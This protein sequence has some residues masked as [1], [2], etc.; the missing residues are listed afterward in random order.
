M[1]EE[2]DTGL[3]RMYVPDVMAYIESETTRDPTTAVP[4]DS[5][6]LLGMLRKLPEDMEKKR[7]AR[8]FIDDFKNRPVL[9]ANDAAKKLL[10]EARMI[11]FTPRNEERSEWIDFG[12]FSRT[13]LGLQCQYGA[14]YLKGEIPGYPK[15]LDN[16]AHMR[17]D[18]ARNYHA[19]RVHVDALPAFV[20]K[21]Q[22]L[23]RRS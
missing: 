2:I 16:D 9:Y 22:M 19:V 14:R 7:A 23:C 4:R 13:E 1:V 17:G 6:V 15:L 20:E 10:R 3:G 18:P 21:Y 5:S 11:A 8:Y 12:V